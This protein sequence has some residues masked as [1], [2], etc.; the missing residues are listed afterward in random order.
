MSPLPGDPIWHVS[1]RSGE[2]CCEL[3][4]SVYFTFT[5]LYLI[6][7]LITFIC[8]L[9]M[10]S[11]YITSKAHRPGDVEP[12]DV[13]PVAAAHPVSHI[14]PVRSSVA[15][16]GEPESTATEPTGPVSAPNTPSL[17]GELPSGVDPQH[18]GLRLLLLWGLP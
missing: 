15:A 2:A 13:A 10:T 8:E 9:N 12:D 1:S 6:L 17:D 5:L 11:H 18:Y 14:T 3:L 4:Y 16:A 7:R